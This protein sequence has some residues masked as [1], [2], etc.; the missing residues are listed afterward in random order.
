MSRLFMILFMVSVDICLK[1]NLLL[2][3]NYYYCFY[4]LVKEKRFNNGVNSAIQWWLSKSSLCQLKRFDECVVDAKCLLK[5][6]TTY[7][8]F[9]KN[10]SISSNII[11]SCISLFKNKYYSTIFIQEVWFT[12]FPKWFG[13]TIK[14]YNLAYLFRFAIRLRCH[15]NL[16]MSLD[17]LTYLNCFWSMIWSLLDPEGSY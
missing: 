5:I 10:L 9:G 17:F 12:C 13:I 1:E 7:I 15:L 11:F 14:Q 3:L 8:C 4:T 16:I 6:E 2:I